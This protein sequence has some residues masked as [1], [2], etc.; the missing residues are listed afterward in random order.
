MLADAAD[1]LS[2]DR[3]H[4]VSIC[5]L[6]CTA[7]YASMLLYLQFL[8]SKKYCWFRDVFDTLYMQHAA[9]LGAIH[10]RECASGAQ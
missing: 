7:A 3:Y 9:E 5:T 2:L 4:V 1:R 6:S 8:L 10:I